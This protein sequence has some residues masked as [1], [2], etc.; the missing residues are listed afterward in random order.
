MKDII[1]LVGQSSSGKDSILTELID[2]YGLHRCVSYTTRP[3][4]QGEIDGV[5]YNFCSDE[6]FEQ[7]WNSKEVFGRTEY[8]TNLGVWEYGIGKKSFV[9]DNVNVV[10]LNPHGIEQLL[11]SEVADRLYIVFVTADM[12]TRFM[13]YLKRDNMT[14]QHKIELVDRF[15]RDYEDF[16]YFDKFD[17]LVDTICSLPSKVARDIWCEYRKGAG[18]EA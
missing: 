3:M 12:E 14:D 18:N 16:K 7:L 15:I 13:R 10:I 2:I 6:E 8:H 11:E 1:V 17:S 4:R 9:N 5:H